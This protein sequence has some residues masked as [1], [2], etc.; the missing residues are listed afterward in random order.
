MFGEEETTAI[1]NA[2]PLDNAPPTIKEKLDRMCL[3]DDYP[4][5]PRNLRAIL[6]KSGQFL[7]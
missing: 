2:V 7:E 4:L 1:M 3:S 6:V 5:M